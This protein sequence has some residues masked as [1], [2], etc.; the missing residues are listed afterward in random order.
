VSRPERRFYFRLALALGCTVEEL[1]D[2]ITALE[3]D[4]WLAYYNLEPWG[5]ERADLRAGIISST[6]ANC[7]PFRKRSSKS[8]KPKHF[9]P[10]F[11]RRP[12]GTMKQKFLAWA[13]SCGEVRMPKGK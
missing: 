5:E 10:T 11:R 3:L 2:R 8:F 12:A 9:M 4:E 13:A 6:I 1:L 7:R